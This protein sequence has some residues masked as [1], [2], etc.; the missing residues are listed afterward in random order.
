MFPLSISVQRVYRPDQNK[1]RI[2]KKAVPTSKKCGKEICMSTARW[3]SP[4]QACRIHPGHV[5][6]SM[7]WVTVTQSFVD[8]RD[9]LESWLGDLGCIPFEWSGSNHSDHGAS[10]ERINPLWSQ[11]QFLWWTMI[12]VILDHWSWS[13][14]PQRNTPL[15]Y[16][17]NILNRRLQSERLP[18]QPVNRIFSYQREILS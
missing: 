10:E 16:N 8:L 17:S 11:I 13:K 5:S 14:S 15:G 2:I 3:S 6:S 18:L 4:S 12:R 7:S 1:P 9:D